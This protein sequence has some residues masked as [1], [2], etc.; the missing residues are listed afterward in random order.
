MVWTWRADNPDVSVCVIPCRQNVSGKVKLRPGETLTRPVLVHVALKAPD[1]RQSV[2]FRLGF[3]TDAF[4]G[5]IEPAPK[6][7]AIWSKAV[8]A[9]VASNSTSALNTVQRPHWKHGVTEQQ[10]M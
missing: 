9:R 8:T 3:G 7:P 10:K 5:T 1:R 4:F 2:P 6:A